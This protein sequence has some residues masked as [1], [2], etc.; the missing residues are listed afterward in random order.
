M[1]NNIGL[2]HLAPIPSAAA[3]DRERNRR[4]A[5]GIAIPMK[6]GQVVSLGMANLEDFRNISFSAVTAQALSDKKA[7]ASDSARAAADDDLSGFLPAQG[8]GHL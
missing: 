5:L 6:L 4:I 7:T 8:L 1:L 3:V 2:P